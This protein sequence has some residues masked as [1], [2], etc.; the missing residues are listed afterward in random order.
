MRR[1]R[2]RQYRVLQLSYLCTP[3]VVVRCMRAH[4]K[5]SAMTTAPGRTIIKVLSKYIH[6]FVMKS[7]NFRNSPAKKH[8]QSFCELTAGRVLKLVCL[9]KIGILV[10]REVF[11]KRAG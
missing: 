3:T 6:E 8:S 10:S 11:M 5:I 1:Q 2:G 9:L 4:L 7:M